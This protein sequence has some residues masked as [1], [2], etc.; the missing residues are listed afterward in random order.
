MCGYLWACLKAEV[1]ALTENVPSILTE[2]QVPLRGFV[3]S[4]AG[5]LQREKKEGEP[6]VTGC[7][8]V[9][10]CLPGDTWISDCTAPK[11]QKLVS[12]TALV[13]ADDTKQAFTRESKENA[14]S[15]T[16]PA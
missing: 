7:P 2:V 13:L 11:V 3:A 9:S 10:M 16:T 4:A 12:H 5:E 15:I 6:E 8:C 14:P 1:L